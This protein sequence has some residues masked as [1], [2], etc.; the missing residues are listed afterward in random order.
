[1]E[2]QTQEERRWY[3]RGYDDGREGWIAYNDAYVDT[4][5]PVIVWRLGRSPLADAYA[6]GFSDALE[7]NAGRLS[8]RTHLWILISALSLALGLVA[9]W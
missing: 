9:W 6:Q 1:M 7:N 8:P 4:T 2:T 5:G 3:L